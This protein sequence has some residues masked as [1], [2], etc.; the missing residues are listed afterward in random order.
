[1]LKGKKVIL[2]PQRRSD[3]KLYLKWFNDLEVMKNLT[4]YLP[5]TEASEE[6]YLDDTMKSQA[7]IFVIEA[8]L[9]S[10]RRKPIGNCGFHKIEEKDK[11]ALFGIA[12]GEKQLWGNG[13]GTE[14]TKLV[15]DYGFKFLNLNKIEAEV[16]VSNKRSIEM[17]KNL[18]FIDEGCRRQ[19]KYIEGKYED[20]LMFGLLKS[21]WFKK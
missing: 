7:P 5:M 9:A 16:L 1:M 8:I 10:G 12:I 21:E 19:K 3:I 18:G 14:A 4:L 17:H 15:V 20:C 13:Y 2:R 6:K 11:V